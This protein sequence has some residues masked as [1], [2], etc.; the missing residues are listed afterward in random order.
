MPLSLTPAA[1]HAYAHA[2][3]LAARQLEAIGL[4][5]E[6][7]VLRAHALRRILAARRRAIAARATLT[8]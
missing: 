6:A 5:A 3:S 1:V 8:A 4:P 7:H 2:V